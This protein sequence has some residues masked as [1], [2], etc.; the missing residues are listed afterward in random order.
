MTE[1]EKRKWD[2]RVYPSQAKRGI[3]VDLEG[4]KDKVPSLIGI[5]VENDFEQIVLDPDLEQAALAKNLQVK[6]FA[7]AMQYI[8]E[9]AKTEKRKVFAYSQHELNLALEYTSSGPTIKRKYKDGHK[10]AKRW[11]HREHYDEHIDNWGLK[12]FMEFLRQPLPGRFGHQKAT[13]R[14]GYVRDMLARKGT[15]NDLTSTAQNHWTDL[16]DYNE[17]DCLA[18]QKLMTRVGDN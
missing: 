16:L 7:C 4:F 5:L 12:S 18:L 6:S 10:I 9:L 15:Y 17:W 8:A 1:K 2:A 11:F 3:Y 13:Y 14:L